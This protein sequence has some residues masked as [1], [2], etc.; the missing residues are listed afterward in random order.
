MNCYNVKDDLVLS[1]E[2]KE[3]SLSLADATDSFAKLIYDQKFRFL[4]SAPTLE[5][6]DASAISAAAILEFK[7]GVTVHFVSPSEL[8]RVGL[9]ISEPESA[10][11]FLAAVEGSLTKYNNQPSN[12]QAWRDIVRDT[13]QA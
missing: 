7:K 6:V 4:F 10:S 5:H 2:V 9:L 8:L 13:I 3:R 1:V 11:L 12:R